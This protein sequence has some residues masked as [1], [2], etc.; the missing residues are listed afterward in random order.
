VSLNA[1]AD[2]IREHYALINDRRFAEGHE[3]MSSRLR[4]MNSPEE[5]ASWFANKVS[6]RATAI[7]VV[8]QTEEQ[9]V[10]RSVVETTDRVNGVATTSSVSEEFGLRNENGA[11]RIDRVTRL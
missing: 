7:D 2:T 8:S 5:Y 11:W 4:E 10:V 9:A 3:L 6:I 1:P